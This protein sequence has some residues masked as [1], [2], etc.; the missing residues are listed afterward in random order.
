MVA[1]TT[2]L[3]YVD[4]SSIF[5][6]S[7][8]IDDVTFSGSSLLPF[9]LVFFRSHWSFPDREGFLVRLKREP[10][11]FK[12]SNIAVVTEDYLFSN[13]TLVTK[14]Y[15]RGIRHLVDFRA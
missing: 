2:A 7:N 4:H 3:C 10:P 6:F 15:L 13:M 8:S 11:H 14:D 12:F 5:S 1:C 9:F